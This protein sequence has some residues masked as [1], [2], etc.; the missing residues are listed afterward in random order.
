MPPTKWQNFSLTEQEN[1][2]TYMKLGKTYRLGGITTEVI[3]HF[4][5][6][7]KS[8]VLDLSNKCTETSNMSKGWRKARVVALLKTGKDPT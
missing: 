6:K 5:P 7:S 4:G 1:I 3:K 8:W 2:L